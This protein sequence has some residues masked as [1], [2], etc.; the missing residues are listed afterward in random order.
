MRRPGVASNQETFLR[1]CTERE[2]S[3]SVAAQVFISSG[4]RYLSRSPIRIWTSCMNVA[5]SKHWRTTVRRGQRG[6]QSFTGWVDTRDFSGLCSAQP[7]PAPG[8]GRQGVLTLPVPLPMRLRHVLEQPFHLP[9]ILAA[10][11]RLPDHCL[12]SGHPLFDGDDAIVQALQALAG[13]RQ[14]RPN[15]A[16]PHGLLYPHSERRGRR[17]SGAPL[18]GRRAQ[19]NPAGGWSTVASLDRH[20]AGICHL[21][22]LFPDQPHAVRTESQDSYGR[23]IF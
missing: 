7:L 6:R 10:G 1:N 4:V 18:G 8:D 12:L 3:C 23:S 15:Q 14:P 22:R 9:G 20:P 2:P 13:P 19:F 17:A 5:W 16:I 11:P 21:S